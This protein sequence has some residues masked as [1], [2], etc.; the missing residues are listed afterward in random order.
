MRNPR[1]CSVSSA[2]PT[3]SSITHTSML[4]TR[5]E[6]YEKKQEQKQKRPQKQGPPRVSPLYTTF[7]MSDAPEPTK[8]QSTGNNKRENGSLHKRRESKRQRQKPIVLNEHADDHDSDCDSGVDCSNEYVDIKRKGKKKGSKSKED[9]ATA[10]TT[11]TAAA[12]ATCPSD[13]LFPDGIEAFLSY[14]DWPLDGWMDSQQQPGQPDVQYALQHPHD[15][16][17]QRDLSGMYGSTSTDLLDHSSSSSSW[18]PNDDP[19]TWAGA[20]PFPTPEPST[21]YPTL[22]ASRFDPDDTSAHA[23][24]QSSSVDHD[25]V[26]DCL[27]ELWQFQLSQN[28]SSK[29]EPITINLNDEEVTAKY[30]H[31]EEDE[32]V[33]GTGHMQPQLQQAEDAFL[34]MGECDPTLLPWAAAPPSSVLQQAPE[35]V[36][37]RELLYS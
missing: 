17:F 23:D 21:S 6:D 5:P 10:T 29:Q 22:L 7:R 30:L 20:M 28:Q 11:A 9:T 13:V 32:P 2:A 8:S 19:A 34:P 4:I 3:S 27:K 36:S 25:P 12:K 16:A 15:A 31:F 18:S 37:M 35:F 14:P 26:E 33:Y 1:R 24:T